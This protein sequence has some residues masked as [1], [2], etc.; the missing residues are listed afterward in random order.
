MNRNRLI[1]VSTLSG[2]L[3]FGAA[4]FAAAASGGSHRVRADVTTP[5]SES[6]PASIDATD[7]SV[8]S[9]NT[10]VDDHGTDVTASS[11]DSTESSVD[12][13][14]VVDDDS[15]SSTEVESN[16]NQG[17][18]NGNHNDN[19]VVTGSSIV[20]PGPATITSLEVRGGGSGG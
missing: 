5:S 8:A 4:G 6:T 17:K 13:T 20:A 16:G 15:T 19:D 9:E 10:D 1:I 14:D 2:V 11:V 3:A 12:S 7:S 18:G